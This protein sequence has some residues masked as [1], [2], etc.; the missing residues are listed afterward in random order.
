VKCEEQMP[1]L[2]WHLRNILCDGS[3][4]R[5]DYNLRWMAHA[6]QK[7]WR[8]I[9]VPLVFC[10]GQG[11]GKSVLWDFFGRMILGAIY[12]LYCNEI[13]KIIGKFN[14]LAAN[15]LLIVLD[16]CGSWG[17]AYRMNDRIKSL[18]TQE[19]TCTERKRQDP[20]SV[21]DKSNIV[22]TTN[23]VWPVKRAAD[24][25]RYSCQQVSDAKMGNKQYFDELV[26]QL[27]KPETAYHLHRYLSSIEISNWNSQKMPV[28]TWGEGL[29]EHSIPP[30]VNMMQA[31]TLDENCCSSARRVRKPRL[32][33][34][35]T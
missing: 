35:Q 1:K 7:P 16:E 18:I 24:D 8:K 28:T 27:E 29:K 25:R 13:K 5:F 6:V 9:G 3:K 21:D 34:Q 12:Y 11:C 33:V 4:E 14:S 15:R 32:A 20:I 22:F 23:N 26:E 10:S 31:V 17:G 30:H 19:T 2:M